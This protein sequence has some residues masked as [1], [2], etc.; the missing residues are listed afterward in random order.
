MEPIHDE[1]K[2]EFLYN[3]KKPNKMCVGDN[4]LADAVESVIDENWC[5]INNQS[6]CNALINGKYLSNIINSPVGKYLHVHWNAGVTYTNKISDLPG[7]SNPVGY[8]P[9][10]IYNIVSLRLVQKHHLVTYK[11]QYGN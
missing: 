5:L 2:E 11:S 7:Y 4:I 1:I 8:N 9:K 10:G 3:K 6:T